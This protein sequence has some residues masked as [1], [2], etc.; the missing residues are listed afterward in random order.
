M[1]DQECLRWL[2]VGQLYPLT[3]L[4]STDPDRAR[5]LSFV[6]NMDCI[7]RA[8]FNRTDKAQMNETQLPSTVLN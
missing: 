3:R 8:V 1:W 7:Q 2:R 5:T 4:S 6:L